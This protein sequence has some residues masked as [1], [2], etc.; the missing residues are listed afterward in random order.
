MEAESHG[1]ED[2]AGSKVGYAEGWK[3]RAS[4]AYA[5]GEDAPAP[6]GMVDEDEAAA[7]HRILINSGAGH[8]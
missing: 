4:D 3:L 7:N 5:L 8:T 6:D 1:H 2:V